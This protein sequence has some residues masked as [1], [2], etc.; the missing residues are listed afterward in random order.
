MISL[1]CYLRLPLRLR[2]M[3]ASQIDG[4]LLVQLL[5]PLVIKN[6]CTLHHFWASNVHH[7]SAPALHPAHKRSITNYCIT[8]H[9]HNKIMMVKCSILSLLLLI[10]LP[11]TSAER[12]PK[13]GVSFSGAQACSALE[14]HTDSVSI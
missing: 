8:S 5:P 13:K 11:I 2:Q 14:P 9:S 6:S 1:P 4:P 3:F 10:A 12:N 7:T